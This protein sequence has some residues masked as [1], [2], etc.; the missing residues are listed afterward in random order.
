MVRFI[1]ALYLC[2][3]SIL[4]KESRTALAEMQYER[5][6]QEND[7]SWLIK[8]ATVDEYKVIRNFSGKRVGYSFSDD[9][10]FLMEYGDLEGSLAKFVNRK[11]REKK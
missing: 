3:K 10:V 4:S 6:L 5:I 7:L 9:Y 8:Y 11:L 1:K 2:A